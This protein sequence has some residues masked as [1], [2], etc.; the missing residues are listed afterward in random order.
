MRLGAFSDVGGS[1]LLGITYQNMFGYRIRKGPKEGN[2][3]VAR[4]RGH[5]RF[6]ALSVETF[7]ATTERAVILHV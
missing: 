5:G 1:F 7:G 4:Q 6:T 3:A 2:E